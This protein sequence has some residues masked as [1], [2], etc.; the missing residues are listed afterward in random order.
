MDRESMDAL[1]LNAR[2][3]NE[4]HNI[5]GLLLFHAGAF[6]QV[7]EGDRRTI[8]NLFEKKLVRDSRHKSVTLFHDEKIEQRQFTQW[9]LAYS[10]LNDPGASIP[11]AYRDLLKQRRSLFELTNNS[12]QA[13]E[14]VRQIHRS[15]LSRAP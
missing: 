1:L 13:L 10:D 8:S 5:T 6:L 15:V 11:E 3:N 7:L 14:L 2:I 4:R 9:H 12:Q